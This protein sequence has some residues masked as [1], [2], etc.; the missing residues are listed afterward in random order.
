M[1]VGREQVL[2]WLDTLQRV[3]AENRE[4][5]TELDSAVGDA[6]HGINMDRGFTAVKTELAA[7]PPADIRGILQKVAA[8][9]I[10]TVGG[11]SGPLYGTFFLPPPRPCRP[12][13]QKWMCSPFCRLV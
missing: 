6:D 12:A 4:R 3:Y 9:L 8:V 5:L 7:D 13:I 1:A 10:R 11:A 2:V